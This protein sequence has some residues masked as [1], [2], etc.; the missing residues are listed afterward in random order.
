MSRLRQSAENLRLLAS[1]YEETARWCL[2]EREI[3][4]W[5]DATLRLLDAADALERCAED[6]EPALQRDE[7]MEVENAA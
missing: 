5:T 6:A 3:D 7:M 2:C 4:A 1:V